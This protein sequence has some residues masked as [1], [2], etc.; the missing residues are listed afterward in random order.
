M[1]PLSLFLLSVQ[2]LSLDGLDIPV[3]AGVQSGVGARGVVRADLVSP[4]LRQDRVD[5]GVGPEGSGRGGGPQGGRGGGPRP[6]VRGGVARGV[7]GVGAGAV[8]PVSPI[9]V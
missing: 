8:A 1:A 6:P 2:L 5:D 4:V 9:P 7:A 3:L